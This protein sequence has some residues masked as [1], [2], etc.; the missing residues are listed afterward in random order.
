ML[1]RR[2]ESGSKREPPVDYVNRKHGGTCPR[3]ATSLTF[4]NIVDNRPVAFGCEFCG[5]FV[6][7]Q[8]GETVAGALGEQEAR[9]N[10]GIGATERSGKPGRPGRF[11]Q[12][13][14]DLVLLALRSGASKAKAALHAGISPQNLTYWLKSRPAFA[15]ACGAA[16]KDASRFA[17]NAR[18]HPGRPPAIRRILQR[19]IE[20]AHKPIT[21]GERRDDSI[22][23]RVLRD[24]TDN[25]DA[26]KHNLTWDGRDRRNPK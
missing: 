25:A 24:C 17:L 8:L 5:I 23:T 11:T 16:I 7:L 1:S 10:H 14:A 26:A 13:T 6:P 2:R 15:V 12:A 4:K 20:D 18:R 19:S 9:R 3:C 21:H 22:E